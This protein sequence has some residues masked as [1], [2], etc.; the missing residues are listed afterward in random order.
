MKTRTL[1]LLAVGCGIAILV[2][3]MFVL[4]RLDH[5][6]TSAPL[7]IGQQGVAGDARVTVEGAR[8]VDGDLLV[9]V[10]LGGVDDPTGVKGFSLIAPNRRVPA[11]PD[12]NRAD[13]CHGFT[14][15][16]HTCVL[17]FPTAGLEGTVRQLVF[18][19]ATEKV[20]WNLVP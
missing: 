4:L 10:Q 15:A 19:R 12:Q 14:V 20:R 7:G 11:G 18:E 1:L 5:Q 6:S 8:V 13:R 17:S 16:S 2:A 9:T 3:G